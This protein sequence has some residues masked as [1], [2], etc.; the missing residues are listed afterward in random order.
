MYCNLK[1]TQQ[2]QMILSTQE[3]LEFKSE[4]ETEVILLELLLVYFLL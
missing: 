4:L 1:N 3:D 2:L